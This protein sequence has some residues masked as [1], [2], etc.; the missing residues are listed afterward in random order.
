MEA[1]WRKGYEATSLADLV[2]CTGLNKGSL[3][4]AFGD[5]HSLFMRSL[6]HYADTEFRQVAAV[7]FEYDSPVDSIRAVM[8]RVIEHT[9]DNCGCLMINSLVELAPHDEE[10]RVFIQQLGEQRVRMM[11]DL[12]EKA[13]RAGEIPAREQ[14]HDIAIRMMVTLA[15]L[16]TASKGFMDIEQAHEVVD[17]AVN[18]LV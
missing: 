16:V 11:T 14:A 10:V 12:V 15:G 3:Y 1:F 18:A 5:K 9:K 6:A 17:G 4:Q 13:Q 7:A 2:A 8:H